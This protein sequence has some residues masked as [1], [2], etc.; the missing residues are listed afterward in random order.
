MQLYCKYVYEEVPLFDSKSQGLPLYSW[1][2][3]TPTTPDLFDRYNDVNVV[4]LMLKES[5]INLC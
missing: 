1:N 3:Q 4:F 2:F 5:L